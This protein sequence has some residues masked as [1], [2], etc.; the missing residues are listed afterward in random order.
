MSN[1]FTVGVLN[2]VSE[3]TGGMDNKSGPHLNKSNFESKELPI[4]IIQSITNLKIEE[5]DDDSLETKQRF[6]D[7]DGEMVGLDSKGWEKFVTFV[8]QEYSSYN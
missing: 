5:F 2:F 3:L 4:A 1:D 6:I 7:I 8:S